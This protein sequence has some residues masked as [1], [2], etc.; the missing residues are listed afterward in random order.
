MSEKHAFEI[1]FYESILRREPK[2]AEVI[3]LLG[4]LYTNVGRIEDGLKMDQKLVRLWPEKPVVH[5]NLACSLA[6]KRR[7]KQA[8]EALKKAVELGYRDVKWMQEDPD[9][10]SLRDHP[11]FERLIEHLQ[12]ME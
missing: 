9:L 3:E 10:E 11:S 5:Y 7:S 12:A 4:G 8:L 1:S 6:L 2:F